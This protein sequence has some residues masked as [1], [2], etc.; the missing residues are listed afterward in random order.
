MMMMMMMMMTPC[1]LL[2]LLWPTPVPQFQHELRPEASRRWHPDISAH[3]RAF[4]QC[5]SSAAMMRPLW[6]CFAASGFR[7][8]GCFSGKPCHNIVMSVAA[9]WVLVRTSFLPSAWTKR[10]KKIVPWLSPSQ[11]LPFNHRPLKPILIAIPK[12]ERKVKSY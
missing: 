5:S 7:K 3:P 10:E 1:F 6:L 11:S 9:K 2:L 4:L 8:T 12:E